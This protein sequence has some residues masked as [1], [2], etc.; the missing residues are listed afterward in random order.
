MTS[1]TMAANWFCS[2]LL[3]EDAKKRLRSLSKT[4]LFRMMACISGD[5]ASKQECINLN[6]C[7]TESPDGLKFTPAVEVN[8]LLTFDY[9][10]VP[11]LQIL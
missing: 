7:V 3:P 5:L 8:T 11:S 6:S 9:D 1:L 2:T 4:L 10:H